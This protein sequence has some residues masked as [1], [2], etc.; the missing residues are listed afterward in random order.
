M[1][2]DGQLDDWTE[3]DR[4]EIIRGL[5]DGT[6]DIIA[7]D[8]APHSREEKERSITAAPSG[9]IGL[10][11]GSVWSRLGSKVTVVE[12]LD[13]I[14]GPGMDTEIA[15]QAQKLL[16]KQGVE[17]K[18]GTKVVSGD[19]SGETVKLE[20]DSAK[21]GK[22]ETVGYPISPISYSCLYTYDR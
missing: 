19:K 11:M 7:T 4:L 5:S 16:K 13:Q 20:V 1:V 14:G 18:L 2:I 21:G 10:E 8:H 12:F 17:F 6:I 3:A 9:I 15:K 22:P